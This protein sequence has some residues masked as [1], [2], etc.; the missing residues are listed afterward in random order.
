MLHNPNTPI[1]SI[2][3]LSG[4]P[5]ATQSCSNDTQSLPPMYSPT[6]LF[7]EQ[8]VLFG[9]WYQDPAGNGSRHP[10]YTSPKKREFSNREGLNQSTSTILMSWMFLRNLL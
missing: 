10:V 1:Q 5:S 9:Y 2:K 6:L 7:C 3:L 8:G 4:S